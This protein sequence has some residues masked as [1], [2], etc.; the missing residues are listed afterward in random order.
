MSKDCHA[1]YERSFFSVYGS[2]G[3]TSNCNTLKDHQTFPMY[4]SKHFIFISIMPQSQGSS[5]SSSSSS[6]DCNKYYLRIHLLS[7][8]NET[9]FRE[10]H[11]CFSTERRVGFLSALYLND[12]S[13]QEVNTDSSGCLAMRFRHYIQDKKCLYFCICKHVK[14][15][16]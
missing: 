8:R 2:Y 11:D 16:W 9:C 7:H 12:I 15:F 3:N 5:K 10:Q 6:V 4:Y 13:G 1:H 14:L